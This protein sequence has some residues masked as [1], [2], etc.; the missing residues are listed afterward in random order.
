MSED[1]EAW[2]IKILRKT[3][4]RIS[5][6][7]SSRALTSQAPRKSTWTWGF[8]S[9]KFK[10]EILPLSA[11]FSRYWHTLKWNLSTN[12]LT[13]SWHRIFCSRIQKFQ[14]RPFTLRSCGMCFRSTRGFPLLSSSLKWKKGP[15]KI[16]VKTHPTLKYSNANPPQFTYWLFSAR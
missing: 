4:P 2:G 1:A 9:S 16:A 8:Q 15:R 6:S 7:P 11:T 14:R 13:K 5:S 10:N 12:N 3:I